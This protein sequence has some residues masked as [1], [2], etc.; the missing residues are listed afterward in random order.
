MDY[1]CKFDATTKLIPDDSNTFPKLLLKQAKLNPNRRFLGTRQFLTSG[2]RGPFEWYSYRDVYHMTALL[3]RKLQSIGLEKGSRAGIISP[4]RTEWSVIDFAC[5]ASGIIL[6]PLY[7]T[8]SQAEIKFVCE[9]SGIHTVFASVDRINALAQVAPLFTNVILMDDRLDERAAILK[10]RA[11]LK[12][13]LPGA[14]PIQPRGQDV[15]DEFDK[16]EGCF[17]PAPE[18]ATDA[19]AIC[20]SFSGKNFSYLLAEAEI[21]ILTKNIKIAPQVQLAT[22]TFWSLIGDVGEELF[23]AEDLVIRYDETATKEDDLMTLVYTSGTTG[24]PKGVMLTQKNVIHTSFHMVMNRVIPEKESYNRLGQKMAHRQEYGISYL[25]LAH[26][27]MRV[28]QGVEMYIGA[29]NGYWQGATTGLLDDVKELRITM[30]F[31]VPRIC[32]K[33]VEGIMSKIEASSIIVRTLFSKAFASRKYWYESFRKEYN[34]TLLDIYNGK[35]TIQELKH[36]INHQTTDQ[37]RLDFP[38]WTSIVFRKFP[39]MLGNR[40]RLFVTGSAPLSQVHGEFIA[41]C[42]NVHLFE[43]FGMSET[44]AHG[45][46]QSIHTMNYGFI[47]EALEAET[48]MRIRSVPEMGYT[49]EDKKIV[50]FAG[51]QLEVTNPRGE[52][53]IRGPSVFQGYWNDEAKTKESFDGDWFITGDIAEFDSVTKQVQLIDRKRGIFKLSQGEFISVNQIEDALS[54]SRFVEQLYVYASRY[55]PYPIAVVVPNMNYLGTKVKTT[56]QVTTSID[57]I[58]AIMNDFRALGKASS[59]KGYEIPKAIVLESEQWTPENGLLT[60]GMKVKRPSCR[61]KYA[62]VCNDIYNRLSKA[63]GPTVEQV[64]AI[65]VKSVSEGPLEDTKSHSSGGSNFTGMR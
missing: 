44:S 59:M 54:K 5:S 25:P 41:I 60:P 10:Y 40:C 17:D 1:D 28:L 7:D 27:Y 24:K 35:K 65:V 8:Q 21:Q 47:G 37:R 64:A 62:S 55:E 63:E 53:L 11:E 56:D 18:F 50:T 12:F 30:F 38:R 42:F 58:V 36:E 3:Q 6:V 32:Q 45:A 34:D 9:D 39:P 23:E 31:L 61:D 15:F 4:N 26:I 13:D 2:K 51:K 48:Q 20:S 49:I 19:T 16:A 57:A 46:V 29:A 22:H 43:G 33:I 14:V 52:L